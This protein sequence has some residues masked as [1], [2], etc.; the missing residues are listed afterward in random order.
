VNHENLFV[1]TASNTEA[2]QHYI[3]TIERGFFVSRINDF[4]TPEQSHALKNIFGS[5][6][7]KAWGAT[8]SVGNIKT[9]EKMKIGDPVLIYRKGHFEY[10]AF[11]TFK[12]HNQAVAKELWNTNSDGRTWEYMYFFD[13]LT[14]ISVPVKVFNE[15]L[16]YVSHYN[17]YGFG[18]VDKKKIKYINEKFGSVG[19]LLNYFVEGKWIEKTSFYPTEVKKDIIREKLLRQLGKP[20]LLEANLENILVNRVGDIEPGLKLIGRQLDTK[21]VGRLDLLCEDINNNLV[22]IELKRGTAG[23]SIID[24]TQRYMGWVM[25]HKAKKGQQVRGIIIVS[26][27]DSALEYA[28]KANPFVQIKTFS[29]NIE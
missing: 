8:P 20:E 3:D 26:S 16:N 7:L 28:V 9:W 15:A 23:P 6:P 4:I 21:E 14:E 13:H 24:Q 29:L 10:Y 18:A 2:Y 17:P 27:K 1:L 12:I 5:G 19:D 11:V 25:D 22:V